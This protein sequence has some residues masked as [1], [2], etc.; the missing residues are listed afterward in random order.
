MNVNLMNFICEE[1]KMDMGN[2]K[3]K[4]KSLRIEK[5]MTYNDREDGYEDNKI[6][7]LNCISDSNKKYEVTLWTIYGDCYSGWCSASWGYGKVKAV[8]SF[9]GTTH[10]PIKELTFEL[11]MEPDAKEMNLPD[12]NNDVFEVDYDGMD[13]YYPG[14]LAIVHED[15]FEAVNRNKEKRPVWIFKGDSAL[16][17]S[18]LAGIIAN[19]DRMKTVYET[20]AHAILGKIHEDII[21]IGNKHKYSVYD[22]EEHIEGEHETILVDFS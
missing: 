6:Y 13:S 18:Y 7:V 4:V 22:V 5:T 9:I 17:K 1:R 14:G 3:L 2:V 15:L 19:S 12:M 10:K 11:N 20:D 21:V 16:G 8:D